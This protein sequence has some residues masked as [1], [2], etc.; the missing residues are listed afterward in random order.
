MLSALVAGTQ[1]SATFTGTYSHSAGVDS[2]YLM[3]MLFLPTPNV[4]N[5]VAQGSCLVE[6]NRISNGMRLID[7]AGTGWLGG[8]SGITRV[9]R[10]TRFQTL[11]AP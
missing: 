4:V 10:V 9:C 5:F 8:I 1:N 6:Y 2:L 7:D 3:Y 11:P